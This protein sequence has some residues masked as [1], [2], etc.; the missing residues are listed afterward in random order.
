MFSPQMLCRDVAVEQILTRSSQFCR[1]ISSCA[2]FKVELFNAIS[3]CNIFQEDS[4]GKPR[5]SEM[6]IEQSFLSNARV[7]SATSVNLSPLKKKETVPNNSEAILRC[8]YSL[9]VTVEKLNLVTSKRIVSDC[10][11]GQAKTQKLR[12]D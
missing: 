3:P 10:N 2:P 1:Y 7:H 5:V 4:K 8:V 11:T 9:P 12:E 6:K